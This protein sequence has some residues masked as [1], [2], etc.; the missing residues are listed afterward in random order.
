MIV[1]VYAGRDPVVD[2]KVDQIVALLQTLTRGSK[3]MT[4]ELD[5]LIE[6]VTAIESVGDSAVVLLNELKAELDA[7]I[8]ADDAAALQELSD[9]LGA[10]AQELADA[11]VANTPVAPAEP[12]G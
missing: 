2:R 7:A 6:R 9:R 4:K 11:I 1:N 12:Q 3:L 8:A 5:T 10:Q